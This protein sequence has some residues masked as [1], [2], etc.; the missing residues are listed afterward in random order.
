MLRL[1][2]D[3][4]DRQWRVYESRAAMAGEGQPA[5]DSPREPAETRSPGHEGRRGRMIDLSTTY[6]G[7]QLKNPIVASA[8]PLCDS[9]DKICFSKTTASPPSFCPRCL[10]NN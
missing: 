4:V 2:Q 9:V 8:S 10:K 1:A 5:P 7:L 6:M 3:D